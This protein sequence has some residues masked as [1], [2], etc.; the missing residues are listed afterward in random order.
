M[1]IDDG[2]AL[3]LSNPWL[4]ALAVALAVGLVLWC[5][6]WLETGR[7]PAPRQLRVQAVRFARSRTRVQESPAFVPAALRPVTRTRPTAISRSRRPSSRIPSSA[8]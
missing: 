8:A 2:G 4:A 7:A 6:R 5:H 1:V 3:W